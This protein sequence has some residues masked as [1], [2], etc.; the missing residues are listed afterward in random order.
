MLTIHGSADSTIPVDDA[1][2]FAKIIAEHQLLIIEGA[3]HKFSSH[4]D[5]L[6]SAVLRFTK[7]SL[8]L[9]YND[10]VSK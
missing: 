7:E 10:D 5:E 2:E 6:A 9:Q 4:Q 1:L 8:Q 3:D